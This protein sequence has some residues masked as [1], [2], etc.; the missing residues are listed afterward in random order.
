MTILP[1][2]FAV[3]AL[4]STGILGWLVLKPSGPS[5]SET[6]ATDAYTLDG[7]KRD[8][9]LI[10]FNTEKYRSTNDTNWT[11][12]AIWRVNAV[13]WA[14]VAYYAVRDAVAAPGGFPSGQPLGFNVTAMCV[15]ANGCNFIIYDP[16]FRQDVASA[17]AIYENLSARLPSLFAGSDPLT[18]IGASNVS[19]IHTLMLALWDMYMN[20][21]LGQGSTIANACGIS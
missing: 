21:G 13:N 5:Q 12:N 2:A 7:L 10:A 16:G 9:D 4:V 3:W 17:W 15:A 19:A 11:V 18:I 6:W 1:I 14:F 20:P 8:F